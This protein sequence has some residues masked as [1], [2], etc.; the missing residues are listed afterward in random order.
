MLAGLGGSTKRDIGYLEFLN[1]LKALLEKVPRDVDLIV[2]L[3]RGGLFPAIYLSYQLDKPLGVLNHHTFSL[4]TVPANV[5]AERILLVDDIVDSGNTMQRAFNYLSSLFPSADIICAAMYVKPHREFAPHI[6]VV[7][8][9]SNAW[10]EM[11]WD[12]EVDTISKVRKE[13]NYE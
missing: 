12:G 1:D 4:T 9:P 11:W 7:T 6:H 2:G 13:N 8:L 5:H 10:I 3:T